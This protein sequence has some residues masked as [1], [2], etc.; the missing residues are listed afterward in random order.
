VLEV[1]HEGC[2]GPRAEEGRR[3]VEA[4]E[5]ERRAALG[6]ALLR[7]PALLGPLEL[8]LVRKDRDP[9]HRCALPGALAELV[10][11]AL[12]G[13]PAG[14]PGLR[15]EALAARDRGPAQEEPRARVP[16]RGPARREGGAQG[17]E[18][19]AQEGDQLRAREPDR[20]RGRV[21]GHEDPEGREARR[22]REVVERERE[23]DRI[24]REGGG[25]L[26]VAGDRARDR[27]AGDAGVQ[28]PGRDAL[29]RERLREP[30][31]EA[32]RLVETPAEGDRVAEDE[33]APRSG[34]RP[35]GD[36]RP[37]EAERAHA[38]LAAEHAQP[39]PGAQPVRELGE[40]GRHEEPP[41]DRPAVER[42]RRAHERLARPH[43]ER[44]GHER[45]RRAPRGAK[46]GAAPHG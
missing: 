12:E 3:E 4:G 38:H 29:A 1:A 35:L 19:P 16:I 30:R 42:S 18:A 21:E 17:S 26:A 24:R 22:R 28:D 13:L 10:E 11:R 32:L 8:V 9:Q 33:H 2:L 5:A 14:I 31:R 7:R 20:E 43:R 45:A 6:P 27:V 46:R 36:L 15:V 23:H 34:R 44:E 37:A 41:R 25:E 39:L 40:A